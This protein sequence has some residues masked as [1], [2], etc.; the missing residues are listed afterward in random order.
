MVIMM[1]TIL[2]IMII[3]RQGEQATEPNLD[4]NDD[5]DDPNPDGFMK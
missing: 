4:P 5:Y 3:M 2:M 1:M